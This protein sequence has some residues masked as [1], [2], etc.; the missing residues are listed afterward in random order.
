MMRYAGTAL[1]VTLGA[2]ALMLATLDVIV[3]G[4]FS[5]A[6]LPTA[7]LLMVMAGAGALASL[8][9]RRAA[10]YGAML[11]ALI[12]MTGAGLYLRHRAEVSG[13]A[14]VYQRSQVDH[15][16]SARLREPV[17]L[18]PDAA[19]TYDTTLYDAITPGCGDSHCFTTV[20][21]KP[22]RD[23]ATELPATALER[24][25]LQP[26]ATADDQRLVVRLTQVG[27]GARIRIHAELSA[28]GATTATWD[29]S[30]PATERPSHLLVS[31]WLHYLL[32]ENPLVAMLMPRPELGDDLF[33][34]FLRSAIR[35]PRAG[36]APVFTLDTRELQTQS[37]TPPLRV[38]RADPRYLGWWVGDRDARCEGVLS[39]KSR[40]GVAEYYVTFL[41]SPLPAPQLRISTE[42]LI[43]AGDAVYV[44]RYGRAPPHELDMARYSLTGKHTADLRIRVPP[45]AFHDFI[46]YDRATVIEQAG[47]LEFDVR[48]VRFEWAKDNQ[49]KP[50]RNARGE[51]LEYAIIS[52]AGRYAA[53]LPAAALGD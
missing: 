42:T 27:Q 43:C 17:A 53:T 13:K 1:I 32:E 48:D 30:L 15:V 45:R 14:D 51:V 28:D 16:V 19:I 52:R 3:V 24:M 33:A 50:V 47:V 26:V 21:L 39:V 49:G 23:P 36:A 12:L 10:Y 29:A 7:F 31:A 40:P 11:G 34:R 2:V 46:A 20:P 37:L 22:E 6:F 9:G 35:V 8:S 4:L 5:Y 38:D 25:G 41:S 44:Q 18:L